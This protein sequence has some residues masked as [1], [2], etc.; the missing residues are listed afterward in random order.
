MGKDT[1]SRFFVPGLTSGQFALPDDQA[2]HA[3]SALRLTPGDAITLF[4][5]AGK[6]A[7]GQIVSARKREVIVN[8]SEVQTCEPPKRKINLAFAIPKAKRLDWLLEK[9]TELG[10]SKLMPIIFERSVA[11]GD[12]LTASKRDRWI[13]HCISACK[14]CRSNF[15]PEI[16]PMQKL[17][18]FLKESVT[19]LGLIGDLAENTPPIGQII[20]DTRPDEITIIVG[21]EG[22]FSSKEREAILAAGYLGGR[23]GHTILRTE[24][25]A[26]AL[27]ATARAFCDTL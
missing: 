11:G 12:K 26:V 7:Q 22:G 15:L 16:S 17:A 9:S 25:A 5:G 24:T 19:G 6:T 20:T 14:Q 3:V 27:I 2:R 4:D 13:G 21:P 18:D 8:V 23:L 1:S 10:V